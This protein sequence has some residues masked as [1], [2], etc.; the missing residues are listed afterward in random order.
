MRDQSEK[1]KPPRLRCPYCSG[2]LQRVAAIVPANSLASF[3][4]PRGCG[5]SPASCSRNVVTD[6]IATSGEWDSAL[7]NREMLKQPL[8]MTPGENLRN[9]Q[10]SRG[11]DVPGEALREEP[12]C[13]D[14]PDSEEEPDGYG[15]GV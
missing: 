12:E 5:T 11:L 9:A 15:H 6:R 10:A 1:A 7:E 4:C 13:V 3:A 14:S 8:T 2:V